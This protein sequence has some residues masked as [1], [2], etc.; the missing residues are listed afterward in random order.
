M[1]AAVRPNGTVLKS[2]ITEVVTQIGPR[3]SGS[4]AEALAAEKIRD[5][6]SKICDSA[7]VESFMAHP[8]FPETNAQIL[9]I[10]YFISLA[11]FPFSHWAAFIIAFALLAWYIMDTIFMIQFLDPLVSPRKEVTNIIGVIKPAE[12]VKNVVIFSGHHDSPNYYPIWDKDHY[13]KW[14]RIVNIGLALFV[15]YVAFT[16]VSALLSTFSESGPPGW[17]YVYFLFV[18]AFF[19][20]LWISRL[21]TPKGPCLGANDN[22][23]AI[24]CLL[25][26][27][28]VLK[29]NHPRHTEVWMVSFGA[30]ERGL[31]GSLEF[32]RRYRADMKNSFIVN[33]DL[34]GKGDKIVVA[35]EETSPMITSSPEVTDL[36]KAGARQAGIEI[37][38]YLMKAGFTDSSALTRK[39]MKAASILVVD[40]RDDWPPLWHVEEDRPEN[41]D[42]KTLEEVVSVLMGIVEELEARG[43]ST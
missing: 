6:F 15:G 40:S 18:A 30:E 12:E 5:E 43:R 2:W 33:M 42:E 31:K 4:P 9:V 3:C 34:V 35:E 20:P 38:P 27:G 11:L 17:N 23:S 26:I 14:T 1:D 32:S 10:G 37:S 21:F 13:P 8:R 29:E 28:Q 7:R 22:L 19:Y 16:L 41:L 39:G 24:A 25:G 36:I